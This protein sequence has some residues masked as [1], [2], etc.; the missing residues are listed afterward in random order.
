MD[1][2]CLLTHTNTD[3]IIVVFWIGAGEIRSVTNYSNM[4]RKNVGENATRPDRYTVETMSFFFGFSDVGRV[5]KLRFNH[6]LQK[7]TIMEYD[8]FY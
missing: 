5:L 7:C 4:T 3:L 6:D 2:K 8:L 1:L